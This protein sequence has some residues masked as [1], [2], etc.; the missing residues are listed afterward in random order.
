MLWYIN[1]HK[2]GTMNGLCCMQYTSLKT[3]GLML[4]IEGQN[5]FL[6]II[7]QLIANLCYFC[8]VSFTRKPVYSITHSKFILA[9]FRLAKK[10]Q[11]M[12]WRSKANCFLKKFQQ[13]TLVKVKK[14]WIEGLCLGLILWKL[15]AMLPG[16]F[17]SNALYLT[18]LLD[19]AGH[20][21]TRQRPDLAR[22]S[23]FIFDISDTNRYNYHY[24]VVTQIKSFTKW[25]IV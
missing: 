6:I 22:R 12:F 5:C 11:A 24:I 3:F 4:D 15:M 13:S 14:Q 2:V 23:E 17:H 9:M 1:Y 7:S 10:Y 16:Q 18:F 8:S 20:S 21:A 19:I 25:R